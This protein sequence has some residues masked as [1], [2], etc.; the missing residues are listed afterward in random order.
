MLI[1]VFD[2]LAG[3]IGDSFV[4]ELNDDGDRLLAPLAMSKLHHARMLSVYRF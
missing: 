2:G 1:A 3:T 4:K